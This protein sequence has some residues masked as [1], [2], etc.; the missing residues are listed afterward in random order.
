LESLKY[1]TGKYSKPEH[2]NAED[3]K[4][5]SKTLHEFPALI[6][7]ETERL[8]NASLNYLHRPGGWTIRQLVHHCADSHM[9]AFIRIKLALTETNPTVKPYVEAEWAK[10]ADS[11]TVPVEHS[12]QLIEGMHHRWVV[13]LDSMKPEDFQRTFYHPEHKRDIKVE[14]ILP[15]YAWHCGHHLAHIKQ[16][17]KYKN[18]F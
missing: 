10:L 6:R 8:D 1:P 15:M 4:R 18:Q 16:A 13:L 12:L 17:L 5:H 3:I 11:T 9:N 2:I 7:K 14:E